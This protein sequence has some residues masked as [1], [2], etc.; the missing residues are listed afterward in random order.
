MVRAM[1]ED[2]SDHLFDEY[3]CAMMDYLKAAESSLESSFS[4][5]GREEPAPSGN[6]IPLDLDSLYVK[7]AKAKKAWEKTYRRIQPTIRTH[8]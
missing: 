1:H 2:H 6:H 5:T 8:G 4:G 3:F 7:Y